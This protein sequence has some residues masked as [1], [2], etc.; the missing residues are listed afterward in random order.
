MQHHNESDQWIL[1]IF[2]ACTRYLPVTKLTDKSPVVNAVR[3]IVL[4][5]VNLKINNSSALAPVWRNGGLLVQFLPYGV[6][7]FNALLWGEPLIQDCKIWRQETI[8]IPVS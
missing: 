7:L 4:T 3:P 5:A 2:G 6:P 1:T 8:N